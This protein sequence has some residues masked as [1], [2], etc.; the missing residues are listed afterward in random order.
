MRLIGLAHLTA[1]VS[2][3]GLSGLSAPSAVSTLKL[4]TVSRT[5][6][7]SW[8]RVQA[9]ASPGLAPRPGPGDWRWPRLGSWETPTRKRSETSGSGHRDIGTS[10]VI[11]WPASLS[12]LIPLVWP[13]WYR[14]PL[15]SH[16]MFLCHSRLLHCEPLGVVSLMTWQHTYL[17]IDPLIVTQ[18]VSTWPAVLKAVFCH[19]IF[20]NTS[21]PIF[22]SQDSTQ[23]RK[24]RSVGL[25]KQQK[26]KKKTIKQCF[27]YNSMKVLEPD[28]GYQSGI[29]CILLWNYDRKD[30]REWIK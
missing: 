1:T 14:Q 22:V 10:D 13:Y 29:T 6:R 2:G 8:H 25:T 17:T 16:L 28:A 19:L 12:T 23:E 20:S 11:W 15:L 18:T 30:S 24:H 21:F 27:F 3:P 5:Q 26:C 4:R 7:Q 9:P